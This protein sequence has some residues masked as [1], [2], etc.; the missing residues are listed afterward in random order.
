MINMD[1]KIY[2]CKAYDSE[3]FLFFKDDY[4]I[5]DITENKK[6]FIFVE[7]YIEHKTKRNFVHITMYN[8]FLIKEIELYEFIFSNDI[9]RLFLNRIKPITYQG[10]MQYA[11]KIDKE[12]K[13]YFVACD[14]EKSD[15]K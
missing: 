11:L 3:I 8:F 5:A 12:L 10:N 1:I 2:K 13:K 9:D 6:K 7:H 14:G 4:L 15:R